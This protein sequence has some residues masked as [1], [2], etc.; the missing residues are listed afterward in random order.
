MLRK[1]ES[2]LIGLG[3]LINDISELLGFDDYFFIFV[4][5]VITSS[6]CFRKILVCR[7]H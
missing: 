6:Y 1:G 3:W 7:K 5:N 2:G 4:E